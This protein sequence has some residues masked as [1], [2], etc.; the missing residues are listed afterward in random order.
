MFQVLDITIKQ[1]KQHFMPPFQCEFKS[2]ILKHFS[3]LG[4]CHAPGMDGLI[5]DGT[6]VQFSI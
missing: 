6:G 1:I 5:N 4:M 2:V 3:A